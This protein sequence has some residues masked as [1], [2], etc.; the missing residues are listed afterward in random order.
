VRQFL[1]VSP[2]V[3]APVSS[4]VE[5]VVDL[6]LRWKVGRDY[7]QKREPFRNHCLPIFNELLKALEALAVDAALNTDDLGSSPD[8]ASGV[9]A[10]LREA[11]ERSEHE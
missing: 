7:W 3:Q 10:R 2:A 5:T 4:A 1:W 8:S 11:A 6:Y 9:V